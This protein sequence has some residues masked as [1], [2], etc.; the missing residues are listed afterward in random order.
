MMDH[1]RALGSAGL[2]IGEGDCEDAGQVMGAWVQ[3]GGDGVSRG[4]DAELDSH[5][6]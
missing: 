6:I 2:S 4:S 5:G 3:S 1:P